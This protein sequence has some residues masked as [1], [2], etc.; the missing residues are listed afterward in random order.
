MG[1]QVHP[2]VQNG[3][4]SSQLLHRDHA[5]TRTDE[6][7]LSE[8]LYLSIIMIIY[9]TQP[10]RCDESIQLGSMISLIG[11]RAI[12]GRTFS[13][14]P[15]KCW[16]QHWTNWSWDEKKHCSTTLGG[17]KGRTGENRPRLSVLQFDC[18]SWQ[19]IRVCQ[20]FQKLCLICLRKV[21]CSLKVTCVRPKKSG[22]EPVASQKDRIWRST[23]CV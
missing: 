13:F 2:T 14:F 16:P 11:T 7:K 9:T 1:N 12:V 22:F 4:G 19:C 21:L 5:R 6:G 18:G 20:V 3:L 17:K 23:L 15:S 8:W 10:A